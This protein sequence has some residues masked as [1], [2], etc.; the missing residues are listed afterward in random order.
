M[1]TKKNPKRKR[2][3]IKLSKY[4]HGKLFILFLVITGVLC[5]LIVQI[6]RINYNDSEKYKKI[7]L[8]QQSY[9]SVTIPFQRGDIVD[10]KGT[11][12]ATSNAVYNVILDCYVL[13]HNEEA[14]E[15]TL[16]ALVTCFPEEMTYEQLKDYVTNRKDSKYI[17][18]AK[19]LSYSKVQPFIE[20][21]EAEENAGKIK[22]VWFETE[23]QREYPYNTL[24]SS[25]L[26]FVAAGNVGTIGLENY[27]ND[28]LNGVNGREYGYLNSDSDFEKTVI[29]AEDGATIVTTIDINVQ[30]IVEKKIK[31]WN[32]AYANI[33]RTGAGSD[34]TAVIIMNPN[35]GEILAM[36]QYPTFDLNNPRS[37]EGLYPA[38]QLEAMS[39][40]DTMDALNKL[41]QNFS[42][43]HTYEP[44]SVQK[45]FTVA[46]GLETGT[47]N[48]SMTFY[49][50]GG[51]QVAD[52]FIG[53][54]NRS[55]HGE[56]T[57]A[58]ALSDS[59]NDSLMQ[60]VELIGK[61]KFLEYQEV[62]GFGYKTGIDL[63]G[64]AN[65]SSLVYNVDNIQPIDLACNSFGQNYNCTMIEMASAFSSL[66][67]GGTLYQ[68]HL[69][70]KIVDKDGNTIE[71]IEPTALKK[72][73]SETTSAQIRGYLEPIV[74][75][76]G[77]KYAKVDGYSMGGKTGTA[78]TY[79]RGSNNYIVSFMGCV[80]A[81]N[82]EI[83]IYVVIDKPNWP[84]QD[85]SMLAQNLGREIL[86]EV[87]PYLN[88]YPDE[89]PTGAF[90]DWGIT[91]EDDMT[92][93]T[94]ETTGNPVTPE[95][96]QGENPTGEAPTGENPTGETPSAEPPAEEPQ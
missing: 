93:P 8:S 57:V 10:A 68:P 60:M 85:R 59:C 36:A 46:A 64:E 31:E 21:Q 41:W 29:P 17:V 58:M 44:G 70:N 73:I 9:D 20:L 45:P 80:P 83:L 1:A 35:N 78:E 87:L 2:K 51:Q 75:D 65:T 79:P 81:Q 74:K 55:G 15:S 26:G 14:I 95:E 39:D 96:P 4:M 22:G 50:D 7:V 82:P 53:C 32:D 6:T 76:G 27:Y 42:I 71:N 24:A 54:V 18:L 61:E 52:H 72:T 30:S 86:E 84:K 62:F 3:T 77:A 66:I 43:T 90:A 56:E 28:V 94:G 47:I 33:A 48:D 13:T 40:D 11:V 92:N 88:L 25:V 34:N 49:C 12:L 5:F 19:K 91:G 67:N 37:L 38:E 16:Q 69:V 89:E 63:P 23:Y